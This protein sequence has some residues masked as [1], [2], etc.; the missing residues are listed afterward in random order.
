MP[1][2]RLLVLPAV[3][4]WLWLDTPHWSKG[5]ACIAWELRPAIAQKQG[6]LLQASMLH[7]YTCGCGACKYT[8]QMQVF[9]CTCTCRC[10]AGATHTYTQTD[11]QTSSKR[12]VGQRES[13]R[14]ATCSDDISSSGRPCRRSMASKLRH[15]LRMRKLAG[16]P[17]PTKCLRKGSTCRSSKHSGKLHT[18]EHAGKVRD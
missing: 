11:R 5:L 8:M 18:R 15:L 2:S 7:A 16:R 12:E 14:A 13:E 3:T 9:T 10:S 1:W 17:G 6:Q 4:P